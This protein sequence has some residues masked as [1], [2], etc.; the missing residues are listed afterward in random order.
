MERTELDWSDLSVFLAV[1]RCGSLAKAASKLNVTHSTIFRRINSLE[2]AVGVKLFTRLPEG[3]RLTEIGAEVLVHVEQVSGVID[4]LQRLLENQNDTPQG[5]INVTAPHNLA[6]RYLPPFVAEFRRLFPG[7]HINL[8]VSNDDLN[9]SRREA[10]LAIRATSTP[11]DHL[12][13]HKLCS[14]AWGAY[15]AGAYVVE[16]GAPT[17][18]V[19]LQQHAIISAHQS[20]LRLPAYNWVDRHV[21]PQRIVAR[22]NDLVSMSALAAAGVGIALLPDDQ[23]KPE[24]KR[25]F[26]FA[27]GK[28]S[29]LW[30]LT[31]P[32]LRDNRRLAVLKTFLIEKFA[33][34]AVFKEY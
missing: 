17:D 25:L 16:H 18:E 24:L 7:I 9:L 23:A 33:N 34:G 21:S 5:T 15:A 1:A 19:T 32:D 2:S 10:D 6:Y 4:E 11:P 30:I 8:I 31:H 27:P 3:Y 29:D 28:H 14:L 22:C 20:L 12:I 13:A 26:T